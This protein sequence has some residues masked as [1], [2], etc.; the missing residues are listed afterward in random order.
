MTSFPM[1]LDGKVPTEF[2]RDGLAWCKW[3]AVNRGG[4]DNFSLIKPGITSFSKL[5]KLPG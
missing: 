4:E 2:R 1:A 3:K 5:A